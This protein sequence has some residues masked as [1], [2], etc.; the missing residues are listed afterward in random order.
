MESP[1][2]YRYKLRMRLTHDT[3]T[4]EQELSES[5]N[6][7]WMP[8]EIISETCVLKIPDT[9]KPGTYEAGIALYDPR[10]GRNIELAV[11][12]SIKADGFFTIAKVE[13]AA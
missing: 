12:D 4:Y 8:D 6:R 2:Y 9:L 3:E 7:K 1:A 10:S 5:D 11:K 13:V